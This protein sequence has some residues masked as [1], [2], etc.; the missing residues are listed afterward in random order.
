[1]TIKLKA[2]D[3]K[4]SNSYYLDYIGKKDVSDYNGNIEIE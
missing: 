1:M 3:F 2:K 4:K